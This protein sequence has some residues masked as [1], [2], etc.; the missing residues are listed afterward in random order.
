MDAKITKLEVLLDKLQVLLA[1]AKEDGQ[2]EK[3]ESDLL[4]KYI[5]QMQTLLQDAP[6]AQQEIKST[7]PKVDTPVIKEIEKP[8]EVIAPVPPVVEQIIE[9]PVEVI[10]PVEEKTEVVPPVVEAKIEE[11]VMEEKPV[12][13]TP[14]VVQKEPD[15]KPVA[16]PVEKVIKKPLVADEEEE[17]EEVASGL[18]GK[19]AGQGNKKTLA[20]KI[21]ST[22]AKDLKSVIDLNEKLWLIKNLFNQDKEAYEQHIKVL[23]GMTQYAD[24]EKYVQQEL[25]K[26][27][28]WKS[29]EE[30]ERFLDVVRLKFS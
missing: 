22:K 1:Q 7:P 5:G 24:A 30:V 4:L 26:K 23:N 8:A 29:D 14:P 18:L 3:L 20:D 17:D 28:N 13:E 15:P 9:T 2:I 25:A 12:I 6:I 11:P 10:P 21:I 16:P 27:Y 19:L